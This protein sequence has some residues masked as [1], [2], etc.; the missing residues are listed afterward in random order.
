MESESSGEDG[1]LCMQRVGSGWNSLQPPTGPP[2]RA[3][4]A[5]VYLSVAQP[6]SPGT[7]WAL[8]CRSG[9]WRKWSR[10]W[11]SC[12]RLSR[13]RPGRPP[14]QLGPACGEAGGGQAGSP[15]AH[16][17][18]TRKQ[19][20]STVGLHPSETDHPA[21]PVIRHQRPEVRGCRLTGL[22]TWTYW[23]AGL[24]ALGPSQ[25]AE[26]SSLRRKPSFGGVRLFPLSL[27]VSSIP[28]FRSCSGPVTAV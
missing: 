27:R 26:G 8:G 19:R 20:E 10:R 1:P 11:Q 4:K 25:G 22:G 12:R 6:G 5:G 16:P 23:T 14:K 3:L 17:R 15:R 24:K 2:T 28:R 18:D 9:C 21:L 7:T 13:Y